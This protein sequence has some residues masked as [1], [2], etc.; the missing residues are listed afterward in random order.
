MHVEMYIF[1]LIIQHVIYL[2]LMLIGIGLFKKTF[3]KILL[4]FW[5]CTLNYVKYAL[6]LFLFPFGVAC[7]ITT[8]TYAIWNL[9]LCIVC[10]L[11]SL[12]VECERNVRVL[13]DV[14]NTY[15]YKQIY[16]LYIHIIYY[17]YV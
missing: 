10:I 3:V 6:G 14:L 4:K 9:W 11:G 8:K 16:R 1:H 7:Q 5:T 13:I 2:S 17:R 15:Y 12:R